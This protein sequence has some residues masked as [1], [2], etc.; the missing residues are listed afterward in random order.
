MTK[1]VFLLTVLSCWPV[2]ASAQSLGGEAGLIS[3]INDLE[4]RIK[5]Q[6]EKILAQQK[7][8]AEVRSMIGQKNGELIEKI[9]AQFALLRSGS[10]RRQDKS[11]AVSRGGGKVVDCGSGSY[12]VQVQ[13][14][15]YLE[16]GGTSPAL[17]EIGLNVWCSAIPTLQIR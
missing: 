1:L 5:E 10:V 8:L 17:G 7:Q 11:T 2:E 14:L 6:Q 3:W 13:L 4:Q 15:N 16:G 12:V 9:N